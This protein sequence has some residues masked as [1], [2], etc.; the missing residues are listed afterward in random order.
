MYMYINLVKSDSSGYKDARMCRDSWVAAH[1]S[2]SEA[3][4]SWLAV[5][6][7]LVHAQHVMYKFHY[8]DTT[9]NF[10]ADLCATSITC[11]SKFSVTGPGLINSCRRY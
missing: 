6:N 9:R 1:F 2:V 4:S 5:A 7:R 11:R 10:S 3:G 8:R